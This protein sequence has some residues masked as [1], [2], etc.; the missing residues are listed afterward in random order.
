MHTYEEG[1][2]GG[3]F[4]AGDGVESVIGSPTYSAGSA[5]H[6]AL[7]WVAPM[8]TGGGLIYANPST[9]GSSGS[10]YL[11]PG[12]VAP[13]QAVPVVSLLADLTG[14]STITQVRL[15]SEGLDVIDSD[16]TVL[17]Q[18]AASSVR[19]TTIRLD[20]QQ[21]W[22]G[23]NLEMLVWLYPSLLG[24]GWRPGG[25][26]AAQVAATEPLGV[27]IGGGEPTTA[28]ICY[29]TY[30]EYATAGMPTP[31]QPQAGAEAA[32]DFEDGV[33]GHAPV[34]GTDSVIA[35]NGGVR[36][37]AKAAMHGSL[38]LALEPLTNQP[39][40]VTYDNGFPPS[41]T[42][43]VYVRAMAR[44]GAYS[45]LLSLGCGNA[46]F[47]QLKLSKRGALA[48]TDGAGTVLDQTEATARVKRWTRVDWQ[49]T[50]DGEQLIVTARYFCRDAES[51]D[52]YTEIQGAVPVVSIP[53]TIALGSSSPGWTLHLDTFRVRGDVWEWPVPVNPTPMQRVSGTGIW[54]GD[55][56]QSTVEIA[57]Y[58]NGVASVGLA[59][60]ANPDLSDATLRT[61]EPPNAG[62]W[63]RWSL[64]GLTAGTRSYYQLRDTTDEADPEPIGDVGSF[65]TL[66]AEGMPCTT[67]IAVGSCAQTAP[68]NTAAF[69]DIVAWAPDRTVHLG[70]FGYPFDLSRNPVRHMNNWSRNSVD[71]GIHGVQTAGCM[72]YIISDHDGN[73]TGSSNLPTYNDPVVKASLAA[74]QQVVPARMEDT[75]AP[76]HGRWRAEVEGNVRFVKL[77]T[78]SIDRTDVTRAAVDP[79]SP[80]STMLGAA[81]LAWLK[82]QIAA[83][84]AAHQLVILFTDSAW[85]GTTPGPPIPA[86]FSDKWPSYQY[87]RDLISD[88][89]AAHGV[90]LFIVFG[91]SHGLQQDDG[92]N[93]KNGFA[94][95]CCGPFDQ[96][97]HMHYQ[98]SY[99]WSYPDGIA[100]YG[101]PYRPAQQY[102]RLTITQ[103]DGSSSVTVMA[104]ARDC[105]PVVDGTPRT[106]RTMVKTYDL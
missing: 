96:N 73:G 60:S 103:E 94:A 102:Q 75:Q 2:D 61:G 24:E 106:V 9:T 5:L 13:G 6:G 33:L 43:S 17:A 56:T 57:G 10:V 28:D 29:D 68:T 100:D 63:N 18:M 76:P 50:W 30:R 74:W 105:S 49:S 38:G 90:Q 59:V 51:P 42:G 46:V 4:L 31:Y 53:D 32:H 80:G 83:A 85:N 58:T 89:A 48:L 22:D 34:A 47:A 81:Q 54:S 8:P 64:S 16:G 11:R 21:V 19:G 98:D 97:L 66:Q 41:H 101:G 44:H 84:A 55:A 88:Y 79:A 40:T 65:R 12:D 72:D 87:E 93:E 82:D 36:Y 71:P 69:D 7:G 95:I 14:A 62:G 52:N 1:A 104:E 35:V 86:S 26:M 70:D 37:S 20:W 77:D 25:A 45:Q 92:S 67:R 91:D 78:R 39:A 99:Q 15:L 23:S 3:P 27:Q